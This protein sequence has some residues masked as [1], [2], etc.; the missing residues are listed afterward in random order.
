MK[1]DQPVASHRATTN[2]RDPE[3]EPEL[4][5]RR[6]GDP[7]FA[8][9]LADGLRLLRAFRPG[10]ESLANSELAERLGLARPA[11]SRLAGTLTRLGYLRQDRSRRYSLS[12]EVLGIAYPLLAGLEL[13][14]RARPFLREFSG[15]VGGTV[16]LG[17]REGHVGIY[18]ETSRVSE[19]APHVPDIGF[20]VDLTTTSMGWALLSLLSDEERQRELSAGRA[21]R[22]DRWPAVEKALESGIQS[23]NSAGFCVNDSLEDFPLYGVAAPVGITKD[24]RAIAVNCGLAVYSV[25]RERLRSDIGPRLAHLAARFRDFL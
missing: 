17:T 12:A 18:I 3:Q 5:Q 25:E 14:Q 6:T 4:H 19:T 20:A 22:P 2:A 1:D 21:R 24:G 11:I 9:T 13:R 23:C 16:S 7:Y 15:S 10:E 8:T